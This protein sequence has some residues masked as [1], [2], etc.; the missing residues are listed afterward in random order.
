[1]HF[2]V[3]HFLFAGVEVNPHTKFEVCSF[4][5]SRDIEGS[6]NYKSRSRDVGNAPFD[7]VLHFLVCRP[8]GQS[9]HHI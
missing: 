7:L 2:L 5:H 4:T 8:G 9:T 3:L 6:Q 1:M